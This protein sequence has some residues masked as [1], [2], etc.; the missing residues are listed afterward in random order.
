[1]KFVSFII[2]SPFKNVG[3]FGTRLKVDFAVGSSVLLKGH[4]CEDAGLC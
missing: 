1:M 3:E 4:P 2:I